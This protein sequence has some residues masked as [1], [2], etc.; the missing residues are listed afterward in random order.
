MRKLHQIAS[1]LD[2]ANQSSRIA[3]LYA[4][5]DVYLHVMIPS[6]NGNGYTA[7]AQREDWPCGQ[8]PRSLTAV[9]F[10]RLFADEFSRALFKKSRDA[11]AEIFR[12]ARQAL[13]AAFEIELL[14][15]RVFR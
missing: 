12:G 3:S 8:L 11:F 5:S 6:Q 7:F 4:L 15:V 1:G 2:Q 9:T 14:L 10:P 13:H